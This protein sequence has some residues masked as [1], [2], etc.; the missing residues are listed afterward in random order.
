MSAGR[1]RV[2]NA[3]SWLFVISYLL[4]VSNWRK[5]ETRIAVTVGF[6]R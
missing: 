5:R 2:S 4:I 6:L 3:E 1:D